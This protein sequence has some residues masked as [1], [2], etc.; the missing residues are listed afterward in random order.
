M[1]IK[2]QN[3]I[4]LSDAV[5]RTI[6]THAEASFPEECCGFLYGK[7]GAV[8]QLQIARAV[9]NVDTVDKQKRFAI[10]PYDYLKAERYAKE[11]GLDLLGIYHS[12]PNHPAIPST[13]DIRAAVPAFSYLIISVQEGKADHLR[14]WRLD[15]EKMNF[16]EENWFG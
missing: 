8:R 14:S 3:K 4:K 16:D 13:E 12:H 11:S 7:E 6:I 2:D 10:D 9:A 1:T 15:D 5:Q